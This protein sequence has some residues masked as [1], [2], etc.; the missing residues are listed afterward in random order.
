MKH[1]IDVNEVIQSLSTKL[2][3]SEV[4]NAYKDALIKSLQNEL[5][6]TRKEVLDD[7]NKEG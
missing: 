3:Q 5:E 7:M 1:E 6:E 2:A 4:D